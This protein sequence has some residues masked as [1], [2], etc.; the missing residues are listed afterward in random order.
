MSLREI[1]PAL[2]EYWL[3]ERYFTASVDISSS[4]VENYTLGELRALL[5]ISV[6]ELDA[7]AFRDSPSEG[8]EPLRAAIAGRFAPG[9]A[10][11]VVITHGSTEA[12]WLALAAVIRPDDDVVVL[13]PA[14][15]S[16]TSIPESLGAR[17]RVWQLRAQEDFVPG[18]AAFAALVGPATRAVVLNFPHNPTGVMP[19]EATLSGIVELAA[20]YGCYLFWD[21]A[22]GELVY[23]RPPLPDPCGLLERCVSFGTLSKAYGLPG[24][25]VGWCVAPPAV[26]AAMVRMRDYLTISTSPLTELIATAVLGQADAVLAPRL[27]QARQNRAALLGWVGDQHGLVSCVPPGGGVSAFPAFA[28]LTDTTGICAELAQRHGVL[29]VPGTC[30]GH[31]DRMRIGFGGPPAELQDGLNQVADTVRAHSPAGGTTGRDSR[32]ARRQLAGHARPSQQ[33]GMSP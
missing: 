11:D 26:R 12:I 13:H 31:P 30:F 32:L 7:T 10:A 21:A 16:L 17:L 23:D 19:D 28:G 4:G 15:Q 14:Y 5:S 22:F 25:R 33:E 27:A 2:L 24:L 6:A 8:C 20:R 1:R 9:R 3:R 29:V 18:L